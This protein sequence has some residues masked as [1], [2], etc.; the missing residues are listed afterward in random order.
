MTDEKSPQN[1]RRRHGRPR[2]V[3]QKTR[4][5]VGPPKT[6]PQGHGRAS[7]GLDRSRGTAEPTMESR[8]PQAGVGGHP[9][10]H[11]RAWAGIPSSTGGRG[12]ASRHPQAGVGGHPVIQE[13][14]PEREIFPWIT[15][16]AKNFSAVIS[17]KNPVIRLSTGRSPEWIP[18]IQEDS[19][20][21]E[22]P[23]G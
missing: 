20:E 10:I 6:A 17:E 9:V 15:R 22:N 14:S 1:G 3:H 18:V 11:R 5:D 4:M 21:H 7:R 8:Y 16:W 19:P 2:H 13:V 12:R 23:P